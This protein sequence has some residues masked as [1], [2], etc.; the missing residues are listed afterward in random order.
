MHLIRILDTNFEMKT[1]QHHIFNHKLA[2][3]LALPAA[4]AVATLPR[5]L[6][7]PLA[8]SCC[9][10]LGADAS[11]GVTL[12]VIT[13]ESRTFTHSNPKPLR[14]SRRY[15]SS[16]SRRSTGLCYRPTC[17]PH[18]PSYLGL[19]GANIGSKVLDKLGV[20]DPTA[21]GLSMGTAAHGL[22]TA[23]LAATEKAAFPFAAVSM[24]L[25]GTFSTIIVA[26][27]YLR[28]LLLAVATGQ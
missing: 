11:A 28:R 24:A 14:A 9:G 4:T 3:F 15:D 6:T 17:V 22:G 25:T 8:M 2:R 21:R 18:P 7:S 12:V 5:Q 1:N 16:D 27:P 20:K 10:M 19:L 13:G 26:I 23:A